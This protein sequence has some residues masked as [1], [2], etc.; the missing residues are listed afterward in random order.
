MR[1]EHIPRWLVPEARVPAG[2]RS[3]IA[4]TDEMHHLNEKG[5]T[6]KSTEH[7]AKSASTPKTGLAATLG[8]LLHDG[9]SGAPKTS[10]GRGTA[11]GRLA[12]VS[13]L[14][15]AAALVA[16]AFAS[17]P[18]L[19][20]APEAPE[21]SSPAKGVTATTATLEGVLN[22]HALTKAG[23]FFAYSTE[24]MCLIRANTTPVQKEEEVQAKLESIEVTGLEP[25]RKYTFCL[26]ATNEAGEITPS[27]NEVSFETPALPPEVVPG[28][29][30]AVGAKLPGE[31]VGPHEAHLGALVN[32]NNQEVTKCQFVYGTEASL[33][34]NTTTA[35]E[36]PT[37]AGYGGQGVGLNVSGLVQQTTYY[38]RVVVENVAHEKTE[39]PI[40]HFT[41]P[42]EAPETLPA[43]AVADSTATLNGVL[44][45][46]GTVAGQPG[47]YEFRYRQSASECQGGEVSEN[48]AT[49]ATPASGSVKEAVN[50]PVT[51]LLSGTQY[52]F[53]LVEHNSAGEAA[54]G[55]AVT[56]ITRG[57][58][59][60]EEQAYGI[61]VAAATLQASVDP[62][63][64]NTSY[65]F[66]YDTSPY[67]SGA[68]H[69]TSLPAPSE[70][71]GAG[72]SYVSVSVR[73]K[74][75]QPGTTYYYRVVA[76]DEIETFDGTD[77]TFTTPPAPGSEP[78]Q[79]CAN[80][81][82]RAE[83][84]F[85]LRLPD[86]R[87]YELV[88]PLETLGNDAT[89]KFDAAPRAAESGEAVTYNSR[90]TFAEPKGNTVEN[91]MLSRRGPEG[92]LTQDITLLHD[93]QLAE[94]EPSD[95]ANVFTP[96]L[97]EGI[98]VTNAKLT[99]E[100][101]PVVGE[102]VYGMYVFNFASGSLQFVGSETGG[103]P[104]IPEGTSTDLSHVLF[105]HP[106]EAGD[107]AYEWVNGRDI[108]VTVTNEGENI[109]SIIGTPEVFYSVQVDQWHAMSANGSRVYFEPLARIPKL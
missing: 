65:H 25:S 105:W 63:E 29:E 106:T 41:T 44:S 49:P 9:G 58:G 55:P 91:Q 52:T 30:E 47:T 68:S 46:A 88:S 99:S 26:V 101:P 10:R 37:L 87:A 39:G 67:T 15:L 18:A 8:G 17:A 108:P 21:T 19:A 80:E 94:T 90:G 1:R 74:G 83:Q 89:D 34:T 85:G 98:A 60:T 72:T 81:Q 28:T 102:S 27:G 7:A 56:F 36:Q 79:N 109:D 84:P 53:C 77:K 95:A 70:A 45:P 4:G 54:V 104:P 35:C 66:E 78:P 31:P 92:W 6:V 5:T 93:P 20:A 51:G 14:A 50:A 32:P 71:I 57:A 42:A 100:A 86:C 12:S 2:M 61:E 13:L 73:L 64:S 3:R 24:L 38:F 16:L 97:T 22:P 33:A 107:G 11:V 75:L 76:T 40:V 103:G 43:S 62:N 23:W 48:E 82:R 96:E 59:I 69:G